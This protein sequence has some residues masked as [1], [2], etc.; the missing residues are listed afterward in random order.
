MST[1]FVV[2]IVVSGFVFYGSN[3]D[4]VMVAGGRFLGSGRV[5]GVG[6]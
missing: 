3:I 4:V 5:G 1:L 2:V 6:R